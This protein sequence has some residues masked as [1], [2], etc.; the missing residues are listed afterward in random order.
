M[1]ADDLFSYVC[2]VISGCAKQIE[3]NEEVASIT[4]SSFGESF[5]PVRRD[6]SAI[7][8]FVIY[9]EVWGEREVERLL[10]EAPD[11]GQIAGAKPNSLYALPKI[12]SLIRKRPE[13]E[14]E[15]WKFLQVADYVVYRL[16]GEAVIDHSLACR[17]LA[18]D[19]TNK[20]W[21]EKIL[22]VAGL[23]AGHFSK[24]VD[25]GTVAGEIRSSVADTLGIPRKTKI[26]IGPHDQVAMALGAGVLKAGEAAVGT[27]SVECITPMFDAPRLG[28]DFID[29]NFACIPH[30]VPDIYTTYAFTIS[31]GSLLSWYRNCFTPGQTYSQLNESCPRESSGLIVVPHF[32][33]S[34]TPELDRL[35]VGKITGLTLSTT[36]PDIYRAILEGL[37]FELRYNRDQL[38]QCGI[39]FS[40]LRATGG[41]ARSD[42]WIQLKADILGIPV[43]PLAY[44]HAGV[45][46]CAMLAADSLDEAVKTFVK[47]KEPVYPN[48]SLFGYYNDKYEQY[49]ELRTVVN[50]R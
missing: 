14:N 5:V 50:N 48:P 39:E 1:N 37:C 42:I 21:S 20:C 15:L 16:C 4:V 33:G 19:V 12:M 30:V 44:A 47:V 38:A 49:K 35:A 36:L 29:R 6:G 13:I 2:E 28:M 27:G 25:A 40:S 7:T 45:T 31:G 23:D 22:N 18:Y 43:V 10:R 41:G 17:A 3:S 26:I 46:G 32:S 9:T 34:G 11:I 24:P 8:D